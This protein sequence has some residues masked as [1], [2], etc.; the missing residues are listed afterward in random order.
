MK[1]SKIIYIISILCIISFTSCADDLAEPEKMGVC[2]MQWNCGD[3]YN[4]FV[5]MYGHPDSMEVHKIN[6][7]PVINTDAWWTCKR[8]VSSDGKKIEEPVAKFYGQFQ[9]NNLVSWMIWEL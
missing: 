8:V 6:G 7:Y 9:N 4:V 2:D 5:E 3:S 1:I